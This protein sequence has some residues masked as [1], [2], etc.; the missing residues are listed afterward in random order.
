MAV[1]NRAQSP[2][3]GSPRIVSPVRGTTSGR[4]NPPIRRAVIAVL[5]IGLFPGRPAF[6]TDPAQPWLKGYVRTLSGERISYHSPYPDVG[7]ALLVR[8]TDGNSTMAWETEPVLPDFKGGSATFLWM[9]GIATRKGG[10]RFFLSLDGLPLL[11]F[12]SA[13]DPSQKNWTVT[14]AGG[15]SLSFRA[16]MVDA[17][18]ELFGYMTLRLPRALLKEG[19]PVR[20]E[21][22]GEKGGSPDWC[23]VFEH[24]ILSW[25]KA[26]SEQVLVKRDGRPRQLV[27]VEVSRA[28]PPC[29]ARLSFG[30][31]A[32]RVKI[33]TGYNIF[34]FPVDPVAGDADL[35]LTADFGG[36]RTQ[37]LTVRVR[38]VAKRE[39][40]FLP[41]SHLDIGY[42]DL[43]RVVE[44][45]HWSYDEQAVELARKTADYP[46]GAR[47]RWN[48]EQL[49]AVESYLKQAAPEKRL[50]FVEAVR[51][52]WIGLQ[53]TLA[54]ELTGLCHPEE[55]LRLTAFGRRLAAACGVPLDTAMI[56]DIPGAS[57]T[58]VPAF[59]Q[60]GVKYFSSGPNYMP[61]LP[62]GG[63][64]IGN[65]LKT[66]GDRPFYWVSPSGGEKILFWTAGRGY[67]W[68]HGFHMGE[69]ERAPLRG[70]YD[71]LIE[72]ADR[73]YPYS[74][75][76]VRYTVGGDNGPPDPELPDFVRRWNEDYE[77]PKIV[78]ATAGEMFA[79]LERRHGD[80]IPAVQGDFTGY[81]ED[82][83][84]ST[85]RETALNRRSVERLLQAETLW[86]LAAPGE[87]PGADFD[88][89]W[90]RAVLFDEH[91]W[92]AADSVSD[93]DG[94]NAREQWQ[95][96]QAFALEADRMSRTL[97]ASALSA[98][99]KDV[100]PGGR[101]ALD[102][103]NTLNWPRT[104][105]VVVPAGIERP[106]DLVRDGDGNPVP[107]QRLASGGL[108]FRAAGV[109]GLGARRYFV[110]A[111]APYDAGKASA[112]AEDAR[113]DNGIVSVAVDPKTGAI[114]SLKWK[115]GREVEFAAA[116]ASFGLNAY[117]YVPGRDPGQ[118][119]G[120]TNVK[121]RAG[122][123][124]PLVASLVVESGAP[125]TKGLA[126]EYVIGDGS[127]RV[128]IRNRI[129]KLPVRDKESVHI[130]FPLS[131]PGGTAR[132]DLG[133]AEVRPEVDQIPGACRDFIC[134]RDSVDVSN[135]DFGIVWVSPDAPLAEIGAM[136]DETPGRGGARRWK[137]T[138]EPSQT[139]YSYAM[140]N[141]WHTN[142]KADQ[143]GPVELSY[144]LIPH[145]GFE[146]AS[147]KRLSLE[148]LAPLVAAPAGGDRPLAGPPIEVSSPAIV[149][150][151]L[152]PTPDGKGWLA[153]LYNASGRPEDFTVRSANASAASSISVC[154]ADG[155]PLRPLGG[156]VSLPGYGLITLRLDR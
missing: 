7:D 86:S 134:V 28:G 68:F 77:S 123:T 156:P 122:E 137:K 81:W 55:L 62:D 37:R 69:I 57:W 58:V 95:Y 147:V 85:A 15:A 20:V 89:A 87:F 40:Y 59:A 76:Q 73:G 82:G 83:A 47:F 18:E 104:D 91:T 54:N 14:G 155:K 124:G 149:V 63:D 93:P 143:E 125:G 119:Q 90:R 75:V 126:R 102:V 97:L 21:V 112:A 132:V 39:L 3:A 23:M 133:W 13:V 138:L 5:F 53:A 24:P 140:N 65:A 46:A 152:R 141:Y 98:R 36:S 113:L 142:Y 103:F 114:K 66:W 26:R 145:S 144:A 99:K 45:K 130:G 84:A 129:D 96:K 49:W 106:G 100:A 61:R 136:T 150:S 22:R 30:G 101:L 120:A 153:R 2:G 11:S 72:L 118:A 105:L 108:V 4:R 107:S 148:Y 60:A 146:R 32:E 154:D 110:E 131:V 19:R 43:Q 12:R 127:A 16:A 10:H 52:G 109:P 38:P 92:G 42:S 74:I 67:S 34:Y 71:Y 56:S 6:A 1:S 135:E 121:I 17:F 116:A 41:H 50:A 25:I 9:A 88:E 78:I 117:F 128:E 31:V 29:G 79:E 94:A 8:A 33:D 111:G 80:L 64:R 70:I 139:I 44:R 151:S 48:V 27:G 35:T 51:K 115:A